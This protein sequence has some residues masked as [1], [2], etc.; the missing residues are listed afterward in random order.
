MLRVGDLQ[1]SDMIGRRVTMLEEV[2]CAAPSYIERFGRPDSIGRLDGHRIVGFRSS[3]TNALMPFEFTVDGT[4]RSLSL[5]ATVSVNGAE[6]YVAA[7]RLGLGM[8]Q[9]PRYHVEQDLQRGALVPVLAD[10][11]PPPTPVSLLYPR[12][13][14]LSPRV[15]VFL[16]WL[17][18]SF[19]AQRA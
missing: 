12:S 3:A 17:V 2:T 18:G 7:A 16:D 5:P 13:R 1:D 15:R 10:C 11:P 9:V 6:S 4:V 14:H 19:G 8:I